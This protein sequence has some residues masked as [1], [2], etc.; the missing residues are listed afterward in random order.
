MVLRILLLVFLSSSACSM[1]EVAIVQKQFDAPDAY[2]LY[3]LSSGQRMFW[4]ASSQEGMHLTL[5]P[6]S[7]QPGDW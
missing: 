1:Q 4:Q 2:Q 5:E 6:A 3:D 7:L